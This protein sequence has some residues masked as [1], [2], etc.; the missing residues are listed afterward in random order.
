MCLTR[1]P[2][3]Y[4][5]ARAFPSRYRLWRVWVHSSG[6]SKLLTGGCAD[7]KSGLSAMHSTHS[8]KPRW[9]RRGPRQARHP[10][11]S[12]YVATSVSSPGAWRWLE[13]SQ[14]DLKLLQRRNSKD[15]CFES[16]LRWVKWDYLPG[17]SIYIYVYWKFQTSRGARKICK[18]VC[19][20]SLILQNM[21]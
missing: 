7:H 12:R 9:A 8:L 20:C 15:H 17:T 1:T 6:A 5:R 3:K 2:T 21:S 4:V 10:H 16:P 14:V 11:S 13:Q 18:C 19:C